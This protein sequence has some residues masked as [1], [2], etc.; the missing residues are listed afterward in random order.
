MEKYFDYN[1]IVFEDKNNKVLN[2]CPILRSSN[3]ANEFLSMQ[4]ADFVD[5][6][7]STKLSLF[8]NTDLEAD[9]SSIA[10]I[11]CVQFS[12]EPKSLNAEFFTTIDKSRIISLNVGKNVLFIRLQIRDENN[13]ILLGS[14]SNQLI[15]LEEFKDVNKL[16]FITS[17][18]E[19][20]T[21]LSPIIHQYSNMPHNDILDKIVTVKSLSDTMHM[22][23]ISGTFNNQANI[24]LGD[25]LED[26]E[27]KITPSW[28]VYNNKLLINGKEVYE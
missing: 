15:S 22:A 17:S 11:A 13:N 3:L 12:D 23:V 5:E 18:S 19:K 14:N 20:V 28:S 7:D 6:R 24:S 2:E 27:I 1:Y 4:Y 9:K 21:N 8:E 16:I 10:E 26:Y 25:K